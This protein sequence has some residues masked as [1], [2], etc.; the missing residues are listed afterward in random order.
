MFEIPT[1]DKRRAV[2]DEDV[3]E[4]KWV[5]GNCG[6][7][8]DTYDEIV[9]HSNKT[10]HSW[11]TGNVKTGTIHHDEIGHYETVVVNRKCT[12]CGVLGSQL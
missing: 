2:W 6:F 4:R 9:V 7:Y 8:A 5:C 10:H 11:G 12:V 3:Y 1:K